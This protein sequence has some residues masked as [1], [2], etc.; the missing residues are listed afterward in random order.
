VVTKVSGVGYCDEEVPIG[1][2]WSQGFLIDLTYI[3]ACDPVGMVFQVIYHW[4][5]IFYVGRSTKTSNKTTDDDDEARKKSLGGGGVAKNCHNPPFRKHSSGGGPKRNS[6]KV[7]LERSAKPPLR[8]KHE[9]K[10]RRTPT[11][12][13]QSTTANVRTHSASPAP[14]LTVWMGFVPRAWKRP[15]PGWWRLQQ[16]SQHRA[17]TFLSDHL[18]R[19]LASDISNLKKYAA[20]NVQQ[21]CLSTFGFQADST[22]SFWD[23]RNTESWEK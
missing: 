8:N 16:R 3:L 10:L 19:K 23:N 22:L 18:E 20:Y 2:M 13:M 11:K 21:T 5:H 12:T 4:V 6:N 1:D 9:N 14:T 15:R 17:L 7:T